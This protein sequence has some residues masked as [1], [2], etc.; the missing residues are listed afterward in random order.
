MIE[1]GGIASG[2]VVIGLSGIAE[3][4]GV[5]LMIA[6]LGGA[7]NGEVE[8][9]DEGSK[10]A[11]GLEGVDTGEF[12]AQPIGGLRV[13]GLGIHA[14]EVHVA[15]FLL[16]GRAVGSGGSGLF[17]DVNEDGFAPEVKGTADAPSHLIGGNGIGGDPLAVGIGEEIV[18]RIDGGVG[19]GGGEGFELGEL[20]GRIWW[21]ELLSG[22]E[23][24][25]REN[26][27]EQNKGTHGNPYMK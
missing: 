17:E 6:G 12:G 19:D 20:R 5:G 2:V 11:L 9:G 22:R 26:R 3:E 15:N 23:G 24:G 25:E 4:G 18:A 10:F 13:D 21:R 7:G 14:G 27:G 16:I 1:V 8:M